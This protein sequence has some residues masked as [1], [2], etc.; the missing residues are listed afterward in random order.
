MA[1]NYGI[2][3]NRTAA[4]KLRRHHGVFRI[5]FPENSTRQERPF[6]LMPTGDRAFDYECIHA[7][8]AAVQCGLFVDVENAGVAKLSENPLTSEQNRILRMVEKLAN[9]Y[10][11]EYYGKRIFSMNDLPVGFIPEFWRTPAMVQRR[12]HRETPFKSRSPRGHHIHNRFRREQRQRRQQHQR[13]DPNSAELPYG[14]R[15]GADPDCAFSG[16]AY[17]IVNLRPISWG[18]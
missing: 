1:Y 18:F 16:P 4:E 6:G 14:F 13:Q 10:E 12:I 7:R 2:S 3:Q 9:R 17:N 15:P 5:P 8:I 11:N